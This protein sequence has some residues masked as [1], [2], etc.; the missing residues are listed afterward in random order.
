MMLTSFRC[1][2]DCLQPRLAKAKAVKSNFARGTSTRDAS[3]WDISARG[4]FVWSTYFDIDIELL[5]QADD[6]Y[7]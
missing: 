4:I 1:F 3:I 7:Q 5:A 2:S 6:I